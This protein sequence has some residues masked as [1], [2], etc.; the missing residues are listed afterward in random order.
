MQ[1]EFKAGLEAIVVKLLETHFRGV[2]EQR[3]IDEIVSKIMA[4]VNFELDKTNTMDAAV[5]LHSAADSI[6]G[7]L[8]DAFSGTATP[9]SSIE[10]LTAIQDFREDFN[11]RGLLLLERLQREYLDGTRGRAPAS[12]YMGRAKAIY[13]F[14]R[15]NL[16]VPM[17]GLENLNRFKGGLYSTEQS[18]GQN[19]TKIYEVR[20]SITRVFDLICL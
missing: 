13:E 5:R 9:S 11:E 15:V 18:I 19:V 16:G 7:P 14:V 1:I 8:L 3:R 20:P 10:V 4:R 6:C 12:Q 17:H 2:V